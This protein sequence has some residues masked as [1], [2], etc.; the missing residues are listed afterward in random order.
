[1][2]ARAE[3]ERVARASYGRL[4]A[5]ISRQTRDIAAAEDALGGA[6]LTALERWPEAG[7]PRNPE[8]WLLTAARR[9]GLNVLRHDA[10]VKAAEPALALMAEEEVEGDLPD[11]RL[12]LLFV[13]AH[14]AIDPGVRTPLM[15]QT[16]LGL[17]A[18]RV[19]RA[20][21]VPKATMAQRLVRAKARIRDA[22]IPFRTIAAEEMEERLPPVLD[23]IYA[24]FG[25]S[26]EDPDTA[27]VSEALFLGDLLCAALA[28]EPEV[29]GLM[30]L[31]CYVE[32]RRA[33]RRD[34]QGAYVP[35]DA[36]DPARWSRPLALRA[37]GLLHRAARAGRPGR[38]QIEAAIQSHHM[39]PLWGRP[40]EPAALV[41]LYDLLLAEAPSLGAAVNR[42]AALGRAGEARAGLSALDA[43]DSRDI[44]GYQPYWAARADLLAQ[45]GEDATE[46]YAR[47]I[48]LS[49]DPAIIRFL[50]DRATAA[51]ARIEAT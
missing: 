5:L 50:T 35:L 40:V 6:L 9:R 26:W 44:R 48:T 7:V 47:A 14:P 17:D 16:V 41:E 29:A 25:Q 20:F 18:A 49:D 1:M 11:R 22:G 10:V 15:L 38:Y 42:A 8:A 34:A 39:R 51:G 36:Q 45:A 3:A 32:A 28:E 19:A 2:Q 43:I 37:E 12:D 46:A 13:C 31:M 27:L 24:A 4:V 33:A 21:V 23:A 30:A